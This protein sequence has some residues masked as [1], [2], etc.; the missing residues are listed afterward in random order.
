MGNY[1]V[2]TKSRREFMKL[3]SA[4]SIACMGCGF[5]CT[6]P[7]HGETKTT[8]KHKFDTDAKMSFAQVFMNTYRSQVELLKSLADKIGKEKFIQMLKDAASETAAAGMKKLAASVP[9]N[10]L[11]AFS[12]VLKKPDYFWK[13]VLT[14]EIVKDTPTEFKIKVSECI[15][16]KTFNQLKAPEFGYATVCHAD[17]A[18]APAFNSKMKMLRSKTLMQGHS[19]CDHHWIMNA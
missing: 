13:H 18:M 11:A 19:H 17:F 6:S 10:D 5:L 14:T 1:L 2:E 4:G 8:G 16:A 7:L 9:K 15:W 12:Y 3:L